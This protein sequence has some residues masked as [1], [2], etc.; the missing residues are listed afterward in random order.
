MELRA[1]SG[2][3]TPGMLIVRK[4]AGSNRQRLED[5]AG[6][7]VVNGIPHAELRSTYIL[8]RINITVAIVIFQD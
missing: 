4:T 6:E 5:V 1:C 3:V 8:L 7:E 2:G